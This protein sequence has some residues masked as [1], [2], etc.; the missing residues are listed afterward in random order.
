MYHGRLM[1]SLPH[2]YEL[3]ERSVQDPEGTAEMLRSDYR[4]IRGTHARRMREDFAGTAALSAAWCRRDAANLALAV[5][6]DPIPLAWGRAHHLPGLGS[7]L[8]LLEGNVLDPH[9][10]GFDLIVAF[11]YSWLCFLTRS[12]LLRYFEQVRRALSPG[13]I[14]ELDLY[15][16][17]GAIEEGE[18]TTRMKGWTY[19]WDQKSFDPT[20][21]QTHCAIHW[22]LPGGRTLRNSFTYHWRLW[23][24]PE[25]FDLFEE[26]GL[27]T[28]EIQAEDDSPV[29]GRYRKVKRVPN[30]D[31]WNVKVLAEARRR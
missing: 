9:G 17:K 12:E 31:Q 10:E 26:A 16:G 7:R 11:N 18:E 21:H 13:G 28:V 23:S 4:K 30:W 22:R 20:T 29:E 2:K 15:G 14:F 6:L 3:Y 1:K 8:E 25:V 19:V 5:D 24:L 27:Q